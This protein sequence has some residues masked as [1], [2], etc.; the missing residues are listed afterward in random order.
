M[1]LSPVQKTILTVLYRA[2][3]GYIT[4]YGLTAAFGAHVGWWAFAAALSAFLVERSVM[5]EKMAKA[6]N[7]QKIVHLTRTVNIVEQCEA[8]MEKF[9]MEVQMQVVQQQSPNA[10]AGP[11][12]PPPIGKHWN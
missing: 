9:V 6:L 2:G 11:A 8:A 7:D 4:G 10:A 3:L 12:N 5:H 1:T